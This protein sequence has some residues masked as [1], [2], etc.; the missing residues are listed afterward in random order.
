MFL[1]A[2]AVSYIVV[3]HKRGATERDNEPGYSGSGIG[4]QLPLGRSTL[5][6]N[7]QCLIWMVFTLVMEDIRFCVKPCQH[8]MA[9]TGVL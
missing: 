8:Q 1:V 5:D 4:L 3:Y 6:A 2:D 9:N 7:G